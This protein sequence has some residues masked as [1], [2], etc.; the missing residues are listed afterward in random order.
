MLKKRIY[1]TIITTFSENKPNAAPMGIYF[2]EDDRAIVKI[3]KGSKTYENLKKTKKCAI[4]IVYDP[5][6]F[7]VYALKEKKEDIEV[8]FDSG[9]PV[10]KDCSGYILAEV[11]EMEEK[12]N[13]GIF[14]LKVIKKVSLSDFPEPFS[15]GLGAAVELAIE[16]TRGRRDNIGK[17]LRVMKKCLE[18]E[19]FKRIEEFLG[20][21]L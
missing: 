18:E 20:E 11:L 7:L 21:Y 5:I 12:E 6:L 2:I 4:N 1:E 3:Y 19:K 14:L 17:Y 8:F 10:L 13:K 15:R 16:L 9:I